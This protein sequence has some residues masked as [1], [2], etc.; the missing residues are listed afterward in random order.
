M[1][2][3]SEERGSPWTWLRPHL[4]SPLPQ[5]PGSYFLFLPAGVWLFLLLEF[6]LLLDS[7][8]M[9]SWGGDW[10]QVG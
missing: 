10:A 7:L 4:H 3:W 2:V 8:Q 9:N 5:G 1:L 6:L